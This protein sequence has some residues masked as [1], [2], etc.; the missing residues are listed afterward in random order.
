MRGQ[1]FRSARRQDPA[2]VVAVRH[3]VPTISEIVVQSEG[4][5]QL[6]CD[7][8]EAESVRH[9]QVT[10]IFRPPPP[11]PSG[12]LT[13]SLTKGIGAKDDE[14]D[15]RIQIEGLLE[16]LH[17]G[18]TQ[19][20]VVVAE[21]MVTIDAMHQRLSLGIGFD[22]EGP[23]AV[24]VRLHLLAIECLA[25]LDHRLHRID[26]LGAVRP[27]VRQEVDHSDRTR[28]AHVQIRQRSG[29]RPGVIRDPPVVVVEGA[30]LHAVGW[31]GRSVGDGQQREQGA[32]QSQY[33][34]LVEDGFHG[35]PLLYPVPV[36]PINA[37]G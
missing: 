15:V 36:G 34:A 7:R 37:A 28:F 25:L 1:E 10:A 12:T 30:E 2:L 21:G 4:M 11:D 6:M 29:R 14:V 32:G 19:R 13:I 27:V 3:D 22:A 18:P 33:G 24:A 5:S 8:E 35:R 17:H 31:R 16:F 26:H 23:V 20:V 9:H